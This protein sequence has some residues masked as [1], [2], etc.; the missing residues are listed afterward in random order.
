MKRDYNKMIR[1]YEAK[2]VNSGYSFQDFADIVTF[3]E[4]KFKDGKAYVIKAHPT[5]IVWFAFRIGYAAA[6][7]KMKTQAKKEVGA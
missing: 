5:A 1:E 3:A 7:R 2:P 6:L 4:E